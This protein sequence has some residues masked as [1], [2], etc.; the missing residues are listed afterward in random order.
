M[1][2]IEIKISLG[3]GRGVFALVPFKKDE[4]I[5]N[6]PAIV[7]SD[8][9]QSLV[10]KK[11]DVMRRYFFIDVDNSCTCILLGYGSIYNHSKQANCRI[12]NERPY[13]F[14]MVANTDIEPGDELLH[15]YHEETEDFL[16]E[17][18]INRIV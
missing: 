2:K 11:S 1:E 13:Q 9:D 8:N 3:K 12:E 15:D 17:D 6:F 7:L 4:V 5:E 18:Y 16:D 10:W 14:R